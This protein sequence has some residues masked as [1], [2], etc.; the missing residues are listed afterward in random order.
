MELPMAPACALDQAALRL[1]LERYRQ[2]GRGACLIECTS[3]RLVVELDEDV[4]VE[5][6]EQA[7]AIE[8][9]CCPFFT[10]N[11][12]RDR[13]RL[14]ISVSETEHEPAL[15][16]IAFALGIQAPAPPTRSM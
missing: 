13:R 11:W 10:L 5:L 2:A 8:R 12:D 3:R 7:V 16:A 14:T 6:V 1:Q 9:E 15:D 4:V